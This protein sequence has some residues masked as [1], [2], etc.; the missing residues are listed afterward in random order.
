LYA[1]GATTLAK[2]A[3]GSASQQL[4]MNAGATA[5]EWITPS[6]GKVLQMVHAVDAT[7]RS[8]GNTLGVQGNTLGLTLTPAA[9]SSKI[10]LL[11]SYQFYTGTQNIAVTIFRDSTEL[12]ALT[13]GGGGGAGG[14]GMKCDGG[15][16]YFPTDHLSYV[17]SPNTTSSVTYELHLRA[18]GST[19]RWNRGDAAATYDG[20][21]HSCAMEIGA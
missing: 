10:L 11:Y 17:D 9:T 4:A 1:T 6:G 15:Y 5:P 18:S 19:A 2:L 14:A 7:Q 3:R 21:S 20:L 12:S 8:I 16:S 13:S